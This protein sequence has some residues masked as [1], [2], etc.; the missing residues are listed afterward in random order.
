LTSLS[1]DERLFRDSVYE[2]ANREIRPLSREMDE[3]A[4]IP[5]ALVDKLFKLGVMNI[6]IPEEFGGS[7]AGFFHSVL[8]VEALSRVDPAI[9]VLVDVQNTL[10]INALLRWGSDEVKRRY[11]PKMAATTVGAY[12]LSEAGSGSDAFAMATRA[13]ER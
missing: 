2:F 12:A 6:E 3:R 7:G 8:A 9:G 11:L 4:K 5:P 13:Q 1:E 10:V